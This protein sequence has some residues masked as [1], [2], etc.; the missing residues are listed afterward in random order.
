V[1]SNERSITGI[2]VGFVVVV[3]G[4]FLIR[5]G[6]YGLT[7]FVVLPVAIGALGAGWRNQ[8]QRG[9]PLLLE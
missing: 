7:L 3:L 8:K 5:T 9:R 2:M 6:T 1:T 4:Y